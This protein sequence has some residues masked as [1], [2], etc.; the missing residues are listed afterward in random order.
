[1]QYKIV[2]DSS[3]NIR[4]MDGVD[5]RDC[6]VRSWRDRF[7]TVFQDFGVPVGGK[8]GTAELGG[9][10]EENGLFVCAAPYDDPEIVVTS[11]IEH[12]GGGSGGRRR[13]ADGH[14]SLSGRKEPDRASV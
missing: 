1:M 2:A 13:A 12:A 10:A 3:S 11:V 14:A 7:S 6:T 8:T 9:D 4:R 5:A